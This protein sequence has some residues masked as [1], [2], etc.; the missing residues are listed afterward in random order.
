MLKIL[1]VCYGNICRSPMAEFILK[2]MVKK[3]HM[4]QLFLIDSVATSNEELGNPVYPDAKEV[5]EKHAIFVE[6]RKARRIK[7][8][9]Y[10]KYDYIL[11]MEES[12]KED[13]LQICGKDTENKIYCLLD[14]TGIPK[15]IIDP[16]YSRNFE[17]AYEE[18]EWGCQKF[19]EYF[20]ENL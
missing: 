16:W 2:D 13:V 4:E 17:R 18:I 5:L 11:V 1:F 6:E 14:F 8:E 20:E 7:K 10:Q 19:L 3:K 15:D 9:D 12:N